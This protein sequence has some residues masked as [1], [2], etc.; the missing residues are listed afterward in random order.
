MSQINKIKPRRSLLFIPAN[1]P[2]R[3]DKALNSGADMVCIELEDGV[4]YAQKDIARDNMVNFFSSLQKVPA[5]CE[6][7]VR[8][9][10]L[11][12]AHGQADLEAIMALPQKPAAVMVPKIRKAE[13]IS[14]LDKKLAEHAPE[15][16]LHVLIETAEALEHAS[17]IAV[18]SPR[19]EML[20]FGGVDLATEL[21]ATTGWEALSYARGRSVH[22]AALAGLD[23]MD[24][25]YLALDD[26]DGL[27][28]E[29]VRARD[30]GFGG[31]AAIHPA[32]VAVINQ[33]FTPGAGEIEQA[34]RI[35]AAYAD[36]PGGVTVLDGRLI[37]KP[38][39][40]KMQ[41]ILAIAEAVQA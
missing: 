4:G 23:V 24:M 38:V 6:I 41:Y 17:A 25:P 11:E 15:L 36:A 7:L 37:E 33:A 8:I 35:L 10:G 3:F 22:A 39:I 32:Q 20:L 29:A 28:E 21:R 2:D 31:K 16:A 1:R 40:L 26:P 14:L 18:A 12:D 5:H 9:N 34:K 30:M 19:L 13:E 27:R